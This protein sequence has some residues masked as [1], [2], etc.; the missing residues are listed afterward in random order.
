MFPLM[1]TNWKRVTVVH[2]LAEP[3]FAFQ[4][5][6]TERTCFH[7]EEYLEKHDSNAYSS[8]RSATGFSFDLWLCISGLV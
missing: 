5:R 4:T 2:F 6:G 1:A 7:R 8:A 3:P